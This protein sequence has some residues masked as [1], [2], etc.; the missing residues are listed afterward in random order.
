[1]KFN[2]QKIYK[3]KKIINFLLLIFFIN[4]SFPQEIIAK[5]SDKYAVRTYYKEAPIMPGA[6]EYFVRSEK[7]EKKTK[8]LNNHPIKIPS[9]VLKRMFAQLSYKYDREQ[10]AIPLFSNKELNLLEAL[11][12]V[13]ILMSLLAYNIFFVE[14]QLWFGDYTNQIIL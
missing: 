10:N 3:N 8:L 1:M 9:N 5:L 14:D 11:I 12:P 4:F 2:L 7:I 13:V 6:A